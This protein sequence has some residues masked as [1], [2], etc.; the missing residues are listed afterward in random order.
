[1]CTPERQTRTCEDLKLVQGI[2][3]QD[4]ETTGYEPLGL[5]RE[6]L[7]IDNLLAPIHLIIVM[8][9]WTGLAPWQLEFPFQGSLISTCHPILS[10]VNSV[11]IQGYLAHKKQRPL[12]NL[13]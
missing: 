12:R 5:A 1:M 7:I 6:R 2:Y 10:R 3:P 13:Q 11:H 9:R 4:R 8:I